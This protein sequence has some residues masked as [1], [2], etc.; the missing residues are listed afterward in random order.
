[1]EAR[2]GDDTERVNNGRRLVGACRFPIKT[3]L[4]ETKMADFEFEYTD[5]EYQEIQ[6]EQ[7]SLAAEAAA[8]QRYFEEREYHKM[9]SISYPQDE[10]A[11]HSAWWLERYAGC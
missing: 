8:G 9:R 4:G 3:N 11:K 1:M 5:E 6:A 10:K 2:G 7:A